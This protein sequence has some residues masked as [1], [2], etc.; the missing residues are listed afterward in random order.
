M[1]TRLWSRRKQL[2]NDDERVE[3][4]KKARAARAISPGAKERKEVARVDHKNACSPAF[5]K[6]NPDY[7]K[8]NRDR[9]NEFERN[10]RAHH[11]ATSARVLAANRPPTGVVSVLRDVPPGI[12]EGVLPNY[13][14]GD[15]WPPEERAKELF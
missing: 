14:R 5:H 3:R 10:R 11:R 13:L 15:C 7:Y 2:W 6:K 8:D 1:P 12:T 4:A 9:F